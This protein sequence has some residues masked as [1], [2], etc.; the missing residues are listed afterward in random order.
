VSLFLLLC[1]VSFYWILLCWM[2]CW[3]PWCHKTLGL[4]SIYMLSNFQFLVLS[5]CVFC[6]LVV[7]LT[8]FVT[9]QLW[10]VSYCVFLYQTIPILLRATENE[11]K[12]L[13]SSNQKYSSLNLK[14][15]YFGHYP[16]MCTQNLFLKT[17]NDVL[18]NSNITH[19]KRYDEFDLIF[20]TFRNS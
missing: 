11:A 2:L 19:W 5:S 14:K 4:I 18:R 12:S 8:F 10:V 7:N 6:C 13:V 20:L 1:G 3:V 17:Y 16:N 15:I 9:L